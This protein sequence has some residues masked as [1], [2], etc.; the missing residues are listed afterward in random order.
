[1]KPYLKTVAGAALMLV[2]VVTL[3]HP[4]HPGPDHG[5]AHVASSP[6]HVVALAVYLV[7]VAITIAAVGRAVADVRRQFIK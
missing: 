3:A 7:A 6:H 1:M 4:G 2:P 5:L